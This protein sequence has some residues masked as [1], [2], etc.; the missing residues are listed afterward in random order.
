MPR[1]PDTP[2]YLQSSHWWRWH[3]TT[4]SA[5]NCHLWRYLQIYEVCLHG[6]RDAHSLIYTCTKKHD[7]LSRS[8]GK[9]ALFYS[10]TK[11]I[12]TNL[13][14]YNIIKKYLEEKNLDFILASMEI[15]FLQLLPPSPRYR[16][17]HAGYVLKWRYR[18]W[19][20]FP[21]PHELF[22][23]RLSVLSRPL[24]SLSRLPVF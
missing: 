1:W 12:Y 13:M 5:G 22:V 19:C 4:G 20:R 3:Q 18:D 14:L 8:K 24:T 11:Y 15:T 2:I 17:K 9:Q 7:I 23:G 16:W 21:L 6:A 10:N